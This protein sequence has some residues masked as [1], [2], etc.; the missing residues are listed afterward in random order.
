MNTVHRM[1][2]WRDKLAQETGPIWFAPNDAVALRH[3][4][5][6]I[7]DSE[8]DE[9]EYA[10]YYLGVYNPGSMKFDLAESPVEVI[11]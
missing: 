1:Y 9:K 5:K 2:A 6:H 7:A 4:R 10:L 8:L 11:V 3:V